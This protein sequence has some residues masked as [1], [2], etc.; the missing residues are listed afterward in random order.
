MAPFALIDILGKPAT[1]SI[2]LLI[3]FAFGAV[4]EMAGFADSRR[5]A[6]QFYLRNMTVLKVMFGAIV[7]AMVLLFLAS[8]LGLLDMGRV[9][10]NPTYLVPGI[11]GG[12]LMG[13]GFILGGFCPGTSI[14]A[15]ANL[16]IDGLFFFLGVSAGVVLFGETVGL[17]EGFYHSTPMGR[18]TLSEWL[19]IP[20][21][22]VVLLVVL[23]A[24]FMF[25]GAEKLEGIY[26]ER[27]E[28]ARASGRRFP[29]R[30]AGAAALVVLALVV[31]GIGQPT[32]AEQWERIAPRKQPLLDERR[33][34]IHPAELVD[35]ARNDQVRLL[36]LDL[37]DESDFN[38]FHLVDSR[39]VTLEE[40]RDGLPA[41]G[42][43]SAPAN[44]VTVLISNGEERATD[45][46]KLLA[47]SGVLNVYIL[48]GG[49][50]NWLDVYGHPEHDAICPEGEASGGTARIEAFAHRF[51][52][53]LGSAQPSADPDA[54]AERAIEFTPKVELQIRKKLGGGCG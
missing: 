14:V 15:L 2:Y 16:K 22:W 26:G 18:F 20:E 50:N 6:A 46:W 52:H 29:P 23:M 13:V 48:E 32:S 38:V 25:W 36:L 34:Q 24:L 35:L 37:R 8:G 45:A 19:G 39:R 28:P 10:V 27:G 41:L 12:L 54:L 40:V 53:A 17:Y 21:G 4:L 3:G 1:Y 31:L 42:L 43:L 47:T 49:I 33:V 9:W 5:L 11:V 7:T 44:T 51:E 30:L